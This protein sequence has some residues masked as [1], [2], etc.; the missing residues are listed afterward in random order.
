M[1]EL[2]ALRHVVHRT[3]ARRRLEL[4][5]AGLW[6]GLAAGTLTWL[7]VLALHKVAPIPDALAEFGWFLPLAAALAGF[8]WAARRRVPEGLAARLLES[9]HPLQQRVS[10]ALQVADR[11]PNDPWAPLVIADAAKSVQG[12]EIHRV[13]P[14]RLPAVARALPLVLLAVIGLGFVP[15]YRSANYLRAQKEAALVKDTGRKMAELVRREMQRHE[16][17]KE[18]VREALDATA[19]LAERLSGA[20]LTKA[21]AIQDLASA[22]KRLEEESRQLEADP[23]LRRLQQAARSPSPAG[24][25]SAATQALRKQLEKLKE[26]LQG[27]S[28][29]ALEKLA[30]QL[31]QAQKMAAAMQGAAT[32]PDAQKS[33]AEALQQ[34]AQNSSQLGANLGGLDQALEAMKNLDFDRVLKD[35]N[36]AGTDLDKLRDMAQKMAEMQ[37]SLAELGKDLAEQL[38]RGQAEAAAETLERMAKQL[39]DSKL[40]PEQQRKVMEEVSKSL[41]PAGD[42]G[43]VSEL[44]KK[45]TENMA[46]QANPQAG[47]QL[48]QAAAELRKL[49]Q[50]AQEAR[51]LADTLSALKDAQL[52]LASGKLWQP[53]GMC[54]G[55]ACT[56][57]A[58]HPGNR[59]SWG[60]GGKPS[61]GV[62]TWADENNWMYFPE[63]TER[64]DNSGIQRPDMAARGHTDRGDGQLSANAMP[65][66]LRGQFNPGPMPSITLKGVSIKGESTVGYQQAVDA[67]QS[68]AQSA[69][70]QDQVPRAYRNAVKGYFDDLK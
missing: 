66:K 52:A 65:T 53:G 55:G 36:L 59:I 60:K 30:K 13:L 64:W 67:A 33:L 16:P 35:L 29:E 70:N 44:L 1:N 54:R 51:Q 68:D 56:G 20:T 25:Q 50:E 49:A 26:N 40:T 10:T 34:L 7:A 19:A 23:S 37:Q 32:S 39:A 8:A 58:L 11:A 9:R 18:P 43:K 45:A 62:G 4:G 57:C 31:S 17:A 38:D 47:Q 48:A 42:Y 41:K 27:A 3:A 28:P 69:L 15:E 2:S 61:R 21:E 63:I 6:N 22:A 14:L 12:L 46:N 5:L 24:S